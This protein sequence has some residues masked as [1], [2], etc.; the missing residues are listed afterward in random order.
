MPG[1]TAY[2]ELL[3]RYELLLARLNVREHYLRTA[4]REVYENIGQ[5]LGLIRV[6]LSSWQVGTKQ[7]HHPEI[8]ASGELV[9]QTIRDLRAM[10]RLFYPEET[11]TGSPGFVKAFRDD[12]LSQY[13]SLS[14]DLP[15][16]IAIS[17]DDPEGQTL[18]LYQVLLEIAELVALPAGNRLLTVSGT[19]TKKYFRIE[20]AYEGKTVRLPRKQ[21]AILAGRL[22]LA[23]R[24]ALLS[25]TLRSKKNGDLGG[26][27]ILAVPTN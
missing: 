25:A 26:K 22:N 7:Y 11:I 18:L 27:I 3:Y 13:P 24:A 15:D 6:Q 5:V 12:L 21:A 4:V 14:V 17:G 2:T 10:C 16:T 8:D 20:L 19:A 9:G 1:K 23:D